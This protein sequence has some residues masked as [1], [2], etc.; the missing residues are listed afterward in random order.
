MISQP[1]VP[2]DEVVIRKSA[3]YH[4]TV[5]GPVLS[6]NTGITDGAG[7]KHVQGHATG[8]LQ[9]MDLVD[10]IQLLGLSY[11]FEKEISEALNRVQVPI[12]TIMISAILHSGFDC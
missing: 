10:S 11:H 9:T 8:I 5:W 2:G 6:Q 7:K 4:P 12:L 3:S 1:H